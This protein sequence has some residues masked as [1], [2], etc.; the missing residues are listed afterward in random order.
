[1]ALSGKIC[2]WLGCI[3][4]CLLIFIAGCAEPSPETTSLVLKFKPQDSATYK[5]VTEAQRSVKWEGSLPK[6]VAFRP[7][8]NKRKVE[9]TFL[10]QI[11]S[12][13]D[14]GNAVAKITI[15]DLKCSS[16]ANEKPVLSFDGSR[17]KDRNK[18]LAKLLGKSYTITITPAGQISEVSDLKGLQAAVKE[19]SADRRLATALFSSSAVK[20][21]HG[22]LILPL[23]GRKQLTPGETWSSVKTFSFD[24]M[25]SNSYERVYTL[26][27]FKDDGR[28]AFIEMNAIPSS[29]TEE[30]IRNEQ[31]ASSFLEMFD[32]TE[33]YAGQLW[34]DLSNGKIEKYFEQLE[35]EW[36]AAFPAPEKKG[37]EK[38]VVLR[39][40][41]TRRYSIEK[42]DKP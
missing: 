25:G 17:Q 3:V 19:G 29:L 16:S 13:D 11:Q 20:E 30:Q 14:K 12:V 41:S 6:D 38:P 23:T 18:P 35:S 10:Q 1:M 8:R 37:D 5:V 31:T 33:T 36:I 26:K 22:N 9:I 4:C 24:M 42:I 32:N 34:L 2:S 28:T 7:G 40:A 27:E 15:Q 39:M 21:R